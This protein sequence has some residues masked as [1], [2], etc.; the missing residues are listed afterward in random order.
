MTDSYFSSLGRATDAPPDISKTNYLK[1]TPDLTKAVNDNITQISNSWDAH[2]DQMIQIWNHIHKQK[3]PAENLLTVMKYGKEAKDEYE[4]WQKYWGPWNKMSKKIKDRQAVIKETIGVDAPEY[5]EALR[6]I[7]DDDPDVK[8]ENEVEGEKATSRVTTQ[9]LAYQ[10][11]KFDPALFNFFSNGEF[12]QF[13]DEVNLYSDIKELR[14][15]IPGYNEV[16]D[17]A[18]KHHLPQFGYT[19]EGK[20]IHK[21]VNEATHPDDKEELRLRNLAFYSYL[22]QDVARGRLGRYKKDFINDIVT[23]QDTWKKGILEDYSAAS[24]ETVTQRNAKELYAKLERD[25]KELIT[26]ILT[27]TNHPEFI[28]AKGNVDHKLVLDR[29]FQKVA[30]GISNGEFENPA[31]LVKALG[32]VEFQPFGHA[33]GDL[34]KI[35]DHWKKRFGTLVAA[36]NQYYKAQRQEQDDNLQA[37]KNAAIKKILD[38]NTGNNMLTGEEK[39]AEIAEFMRIFSISTREQVPSVL[40]N[41]EYEGKEVDEN[42]IP[43]LENIKLQR[44]LTELDI[45]G[46]T[47]GTDTYKAYLAEVQAPNSVGSVDKGPGSFTYRNRAIKARV[48]FTLTMDVQEVEGNPKAAIMLEKA[49]A[50]YNE[51]FYGH[52]SSDGSITLSQAHTEAMNQV[53][54]LLTDPEAG[55][56][57]TSVAD[58]DSIKIVNKAIA[59]VAKNPDLLNQSKPLEGEEPYIELASKYLDGYINGRGGTAPNYYKSMSAKLGVTPDKLVRTRLE[60]LGKIKEGEVVFPEE[61]KPGERLLVNPT[62]AKTIRVYKMNEGDNW[63]IEQSKSPTAIA[64]GGY[65]SVSDKDGNYSNIEEAAGKPMEAITIGDVVN[66]IGNDYTGFGIFEIPSYDLIDIIQN[67]G[68]SL[69]MIFDEDG[70]DFLYLAAL[71]NKAQKA[72]KYTGVVTEYRRLVN[73]DKDLHDK[74]NELAGDLVKGKP[75]L[76]LNNLSP[77]VAKE[78]IRELTQ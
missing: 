61:G 62:A 8:K 56:E 63:M 32:N 47:R 6:N 59:N 21:S 15:G 55:T 51:A 68:I 66:L 11:I 7:L 33:Q 78:F 5:K 1:T 71:R 42:I 58:L 16:A 12:N 19:E 22:H 40:L 4:E 17:E 27:H 31:A 20:P 53:K 48:A 72:Q 14:D 30:D 18:I 2:Y 10:N 13:D 60:A 41:M 77:D 74:F 75:W 29:Y 36:K 54:D 38:K 52:K 70:Q 28:N 43:R 39:T 37:E 73:I 35:K 9:T 25:P 67:N 49:E 76:D 24:L 65:L 44:P 64:N 46:L 3:S 26:Q 50:I 57:R 34:R 69:D 23:Q 45:K